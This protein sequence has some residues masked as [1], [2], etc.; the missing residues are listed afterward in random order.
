[1]RRHYCY[2]HL[3]SERTEA[4]RWQVTCPS[5][6][7]CQMSM[8]RFYLSLAPKLM[9]LITHSTPLHTCAH[10]CTHIYPY[11]HT[12]HCPQYIWVPISLAASQIIQL[13]NF[14]FWQVSTDFPW[15]TG[16][17]LSLGLTWA[18][19]RAPYPRLSGST[20]RRKGGHPAHGS[21]CKGRPVRRRPELETIDH[22]FTGINE[23]SPCL[24]RAD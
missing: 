8:L 21:F 24:W 15:R 10:E 1:M 23:A 5:S 12:P 7:S 2:L 13:L 20:A 3:Q 22:L 19:P 6:Q 9:N 17:G 11:T 16:P 18:P 14:S 4:W